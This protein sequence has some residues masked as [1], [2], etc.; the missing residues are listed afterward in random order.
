MIQKWIDHLWPRPLAFR[1][2]ITTELSPRTLD[3]AI[4]L[5]CDRCDLRSSQVDVMQMRDKSP[6][7]DRVLFPRAWTARD[8][9]STWSFLRHPIDVAV[10]PR[11]ISWHDIPRLSKWCIGHA[12][13]YAR[14]KCTCDCVQCTRVKLVPS[15]SRSPLFPPVH[16]FLFLFFFFLSFSLAFVSFRLRGITS[17]RNHGNH[18]AGA[19][20]VGMQALI[21]RAIRYKAIYGATGR[22][23]TSGRTTNEFFSASAFCMVFTHPSRPGNDRRLSHSLKVSLVLSSAFFQCIVAI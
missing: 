14:G 21:C 5:R 16:I 1:Y 18:A 13:I 17:R 15:R 23:A 9:M 11:R 10:A 8:A 7:S 12:N 2:S 22:I 19:E 3:R 20:S 6:A 4:I